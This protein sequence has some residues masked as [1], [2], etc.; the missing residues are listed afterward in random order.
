MG[1]GPIALPKQS[2]F[3]LLDTSTWSAAGDDRIKLPIT[4][5]YHSLKL[6][7]VGDVTISGGTTS[8]TVHPEGTVG[9]IREITL[10]ATSGRR[11]N[12]GKIKNADLAAMYQLIHILNG[13]APSMVSLANGDVQANTAIRANIPI[14]FALMH[15]ADP[16]ETLLNATELSSLTA[17]ISWGD[18]TD[19]VTGGDRTNTL[20]SASLAISGKEYTDVA[21][22]RNRYGVNSMYFLEEV[23]TSSNARLAIDLKRGYILRGLLVKQFTQAGNIHTP[24]ETVINSLQL[25]INR[26]VHKDYNTF[27]ILKD[28]NQEDYNIGTLPTGYAFIDLMS[29]GRFDT[30]VDTSKFRNVELVLDVTGVANSRVRV[31]PIEIIPS[32]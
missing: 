2:K 12:I 7:L 24:V 8:G 21:T 15:S 26:D 6:Q 11:R 20:N 5:V 30:L 25:E 9:L 14:P 28:K 3:R 31:Y 32:Q 10:E 1:N 18:A 13:Q 17:I 4:E 27:N 29:E 23:T 16:R 19:L 22:K